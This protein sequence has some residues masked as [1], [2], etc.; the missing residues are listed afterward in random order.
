MGNGPSLTEL[1]P[2]P[3]RELTK[4]DVLSVNRPDDR[5]WPTAYWAFCDVSQYKRHA[6]LIREY[7]GTLI[8]S[9]SVPPCGRR[10]VRIKNL[11]NKGFSLDLGR[12][13]HIGRSTVYANMQT[14][15]WMGYERIYVLGCDM[16]PDGLNGKLWYYGV[17]PDVKP[18]ARGPRFKDEAEHYQ[19]AAGVLP[20]SV[21]AKFWFCSAYN[22]WPFVGLYNRLDHR[23]AVHHVRECDKELNS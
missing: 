10:Q 19:H 6:D 4:V 16:N 2:S 23:L 21:R 14:A 18:G 13:Y 8:N 22:Q 15:V 11:S 12:G 9:T 20:H 7:R 1:D 3:L 5:V 17:N